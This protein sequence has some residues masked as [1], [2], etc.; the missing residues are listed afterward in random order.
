MNKPRAKKSSEDTGIGWTNG[1]GGD[2]Q[3]RKV[4]KRANGRKRW[5]KVGEMMYHL[6]LHV[7][8]TPFPTFAWLGF[9]FSHWRTSSLSS[10]A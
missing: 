3:A 10:F 2:D 6:F 8:D 9:T 1:E 7:Q 5:A 4:K